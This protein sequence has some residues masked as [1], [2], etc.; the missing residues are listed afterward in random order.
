MA[1]EAELLPK[2]NIKNILGVDALG[3]PGLMPSPKQS[4]AFRLMRGWEESR[5]TW[6]II[7]GDSTSISNTWLLLLI[8]MA[9]AIYT[10]VTFKIYYWNDGNNNYD[11]GVVVGP[12][13][14][15][16][17]CHVFSSSV[18]GR[19]STKN[20]G[21]QFNAAY[22]SPSVNG[23]ITGTLPTSAD[24][25]VLNHGHNEDVTAAPESH[26]LQKLCVLDTLQM[27]HPG[28]GLCI[29]SQN[30]LQN[31]D[32]ERNNALGSRIA[33]Q[34]K[35]ASLIDVTGL[36]HSLGKNPIYYADNTHPNAAG[37]QLIAD[38]IWQQEFL[39]AA[40]FRSPL[41]PTLAQ[42]G[43]S[44][45][46]N[47]DF[48]SI[49]GGVPD[50]MT[51]V[52]CTGAADTTNF[53]TGSQGLQLT[54]DGAT[55]VSYVQWE[56]TGNSLKR[57]KNKFIT[58]AARVFIP[59]GNTD[60][61]AGQLLLQGSDGVGWRGW[62]QT[63]TGGARGGFFWMAVTGRVTDNATFMRARLHCSNGGGATAGRKVTFDRY[64]IFVGSYPYDI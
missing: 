44:L 38:L 4:S 49:T 17:T 40:S 26:A 18:A 9:A 25:I 42:M 24:W 62:G 19:Q 32:T 51:I 12:G 36:Y 35:N 45:V 27:R 47:G 13:T 28:A 58:L 52:G 22:S 7:D 21:S 37:Y 23:G 56:F 60:S 33:A 2:L 34:L 57:L 64:G 5:D 29:V 31:A 3:L 59:S 1:G 6:V 55:G 50:G 14:G 39:G 8:A 30:P 15:S 46:T 54:S 10:N 41:E 48:A 11:A 43:K 63:Q 53:E 16:V 61:A 20:F